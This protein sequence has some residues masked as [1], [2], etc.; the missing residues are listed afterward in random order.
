M[1]KE[2]IMFLLRARLEDTIDYRG[3]YLSQYE[4]SNDEVFRARYLKLIEE[5]NAHIRLLECIIGHI[6]FEDL[7]RKLD[8]EE[9]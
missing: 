9:V 3:D 8:N 6:E 7:K 2:D 1:G 4:G 5:C